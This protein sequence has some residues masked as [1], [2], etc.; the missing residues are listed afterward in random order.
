MEQP[1]LLGQPTELLIKQLSDPGITLKDLDNFCNSNSELREACRTNPLFIALREGKTPAVD[2]EVQYEV[3]GQDAR[4]YI[5]AVTRTIFIKIYSKVKDIVLI[6]QIADHDGGEVDRGRTD[7]TLSYSTNISNIIQ[8]YP[9]SFMVPMSD[10]LSS[11]KEYDTKASGEQLWKDEFRSYRFDP[12]G[13]FSS[14]YLTKVTSPFPGVRY[15]PLEYERAD[16]EG[17]RIADEEGFIIPLEFF[18][19]ILEVIQSIQSSGESGKATIMLNGD[20]YYYP[21]ENMYVYI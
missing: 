19:S 13:Q 3:V 18:R 11:L 5:E 14:R 17:E 10:I 9:A 15:H 12:R 7:P 8:N 1:S 6:N 21:L 16:E 4:N 2:I 20:V